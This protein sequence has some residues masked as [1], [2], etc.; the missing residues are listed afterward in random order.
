MAS[1]VG[2]LSQ[3]T[4]SSGLIVQNQQVASGIYAARGTSAG[5]G[6]TYPRKRLVTSQSDLYYRIRF[7]VI[8]QAANTVNLMKFRSATDAAILSVSINNVG[9]LSYRNDIAGTS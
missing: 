2:T 4:T 6:A 5:G 9:R 7:K 1:R 3:W 8:N